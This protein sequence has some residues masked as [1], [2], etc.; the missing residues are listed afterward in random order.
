MTSS[1]LLKERVTPAWFDEAKLGIFVH[2]NPAAIPGFAPRRN[3]REMPDDPEM[4]KTWRRLPYAEMYQNTLNVPGSLTAEYHKARYGDQTYDDFVATFRDEMIPK[5]DPNPIAD[6]IAQSGARYSVMYTKMEDGFVPYPT[7][8]PNPFKERW[9]SER[10]VVG[11]LAD[12]VRARGVRFG[13]G[14]SGGMDWTFPGDLPLRKFDSVTRTMHYDE[15]YREYTVAHLR[16]M[17]DRYKPEVLW[18]DWS[19]PPGTDLVSLFTYYFENVPEGVVNNRFD[20]PPFRD[21][22]THTGDVYA[23]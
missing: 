5:W 7:A 19:L 14:F 6:L 8:H 22:T 16:E 11:E 13:V 4:I 10:D 23:D 9:A 2:W 15:Q 20:P 12:A 1:D 17:I 18:N 3:L 21:M